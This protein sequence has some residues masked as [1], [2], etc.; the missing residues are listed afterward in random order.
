MLLAGRAD[1][2]QPLHVL[3]PPKPAALPRGRAVG[4]SKGLSGLTT[5]GP[6]LSR[7]HLLRSARLWSPLFEERRSQTLVRV[8]LGLPPAGRAQ[9]G[10]DLAEREEL[11]AGDFPRA[12]DAAAVPARCRRGTPQSAHSACPGRSPDWLGAVPGDCRRSRQRRRRYGPPGRC[13]RGG[14]AC[15]EGGLPAPP[16]SPS[17]RQLVRHPRRR[18]GRR[19]PPRGCDPPPGQLL[20]GG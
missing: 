8:L 13:R 14:R 9:A 3:L 17:S 12:P 4:P 10:D 2:D 15:L 6:R 16:T 1:R 19:E 7:R 5:V 11:D 20:P 18:S